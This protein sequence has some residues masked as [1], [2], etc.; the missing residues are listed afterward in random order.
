MHYDPNYKNQFFRDSSN[1]FNFKEMIETL[2]TELAV[3]D[4][5]VPMPRT[6]TS[7]I[8]WFAFFIILGLILLT[9]AIIWFTTKSLLLILVVFV[10]QAFLT[11]GIMAVVYV[12]AGAVHRRS[13][14]E[15]VEA[16]CIGYSISGNDSNGG[17]IS[18]SPVFE[19]EYDGYKFK[20]FDGV[21]DNF[22]RVPLVSEKTKILINPSDPED[23]VWNFG[24]NRAF[25]LILAGVFATVL[26]TAMFL[27]VIND[28]N[29]LNAALGDDTPKIE[30][31]GE[32]NAGSEAAPAE[33]E[34]VIR[35][36]D[37]GRIIMDDAYIRHEVWYAFPDSDYVVKYRTITETEFMEE[38]WLSVKFD[39][40]PDFSESEWWYVKDDIT[41]EVR[42][43][44]P[45][46]ELIFTESKNEQA[47]S[48]VFSTKEYV[49][50]VK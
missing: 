7:K 49:L 27:V 16:T 31:A 1:S 50:D 47:G 24:N 43:L 15:A 22:T 39:P 34:F 3:R 5:K 41:D 40:D 36:S 45:G 17:G 18:R 46:D 35:Y 23:I 4:A 30:A 44:K 13:C 10:L 25:F 14:T 19:Y 9:A 26:S 2:R 21:Y 42:N 6:K 11:V 20:A 12:V 28:E 8:V 38:D 48:W 37:D 33:E 29:F 32:Q